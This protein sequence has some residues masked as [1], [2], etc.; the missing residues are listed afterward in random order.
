MPDR[1]GDEPA[2]HHH[3]Q[4]I[5]EC[6]LCD[7]E[8]YRGSRVCDHVDYRPAAQR[9]MYLIR[10]VLEGKQQQHQEESSSE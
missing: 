3:P 2:E 6:D 4:T 8:G 1:Y 7:D 9:G 5:A 10:Q